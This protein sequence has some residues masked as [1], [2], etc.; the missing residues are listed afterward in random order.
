MENILLL[1]LGVT[2]IVIGCC[3]IKHKLMFL[4]AG[5]NQVSLT[6]DQSK[7]LGKIVGNFIL[8]TGILVT[9]DYIR[10]NYFSSSDEKIFYIVMGISFIIGLII[11]TSQIFKLFRRGK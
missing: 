4:I 11:M 1:I 5:Y 7:A 8:L 3:L 2:F 6:N 10:I 9:I